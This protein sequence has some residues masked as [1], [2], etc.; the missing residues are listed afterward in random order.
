MLNLVDPSSKKRA[1][2]DDDV[3][4]D[5]YIWKIS[6]G[7]KN[8]SDAMAMDITAVFMSELNMVDE[9]SCLVPV[10]SYKGATEVNAALAAIVFFSRQCC[11]NGIYDRRNQGDVES[12]DSESDL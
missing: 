6:Y 11:Y 1:P 2:V 4:A 3:L 5:Y 9:S 10:P 8:A 7:L 12:G